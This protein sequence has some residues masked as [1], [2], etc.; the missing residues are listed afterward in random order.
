MH[1]CQTPCSKNLV[2]PIST[3]ASKALVGSLDF[4]PVRSP[5]TSLGWCHN[6]TTGE[7]GP[8]PLSGDKEPPPLRCQMKPPTSK[9]GISTP[10]QD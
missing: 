3:H 10:A 5:N 9:A 8:S 4:Y 2:A 7:S 6:M 1:P